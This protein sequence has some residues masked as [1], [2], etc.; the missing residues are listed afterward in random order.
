M[1]SSDDATFLLHVLKVWKKVRISQS[2]SRDY[3]EEDKV[4]SIEVKLRMI[5]NQEIDQN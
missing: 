4:E 2:C 1:L 5:E 3:H